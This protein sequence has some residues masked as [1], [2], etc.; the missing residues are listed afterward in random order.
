MARWALE[1][2]EEISGKSRGRAASGAGCVAR[3]E[4][5]RPEINKDCLFW[6]METVPDARIRVACAWPMPVARR[7]REHKL[8]GMKEMKI[9]NATDGGP[10]LDRRA[11]SGLCACQ[12]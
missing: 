5:A 11:E 9:K 12:L 8:G 10:G 3:P 7:M 1:D 6:R 2:S 4:T